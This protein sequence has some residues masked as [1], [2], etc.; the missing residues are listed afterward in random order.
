MCSFKARR[1]VTTILKSTEAIRAD[2]LDPLAQKVADA[3]HRGMQLRAA[4]ET[5]IAPPGVEPTPPVIEPTKVAE[6]QGDPSEEE[7]EATAEA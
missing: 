6:P 7:P 2:E 1:I 4:I 3:V 5:D